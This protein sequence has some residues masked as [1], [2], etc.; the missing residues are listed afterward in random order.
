MFSLLTK[1]TGEIQTETGLDQIL[2]LNQELFNNFPDPIYIIN[3]AGHF[4][5]VNE[6]ACLLT[7]MSREEMQNF[8]FVP[9]MDPAYLDITR[10][11]FA[12]ACQ[13][14]PQQ[15]QTAIVTNT[16]LKHLDITN[17]PIK[18]EGGVV[19]VFG[20]AKDITSKRQKELDLQKY[21][22][23][24]KAQNEELE[25]L[26]KI[27]AHDMRKPLSNTIS[28]ARLLAG[29]NLPAENEKEVKSLLLRT[30][31]SLDSMVRDLN[32]VIALRFAGKDSQE[33]VFVA[34]SLHHILALF[35]LEIKSIQAQVSIQADPALSLVTMKA[36]FD[37]ILRNL[38]SNALKYHSSQ[39]R[40][41]LVVRAEV[42]KGELV[43]SV[44]DN[45]VGMDMSQVS[46]DLF[47][48]YRR[49]APALAEGKGLGLYIVR[50]QVNLLG[51]SIDVKSEPGIGSE[52]LLTLPV[53]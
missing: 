42:N 1:D 25:M 40:P 32:E 28:F 20:I 53:A 4:M 47:K 24:L 6:Q 5:M 22:D 16:G 23:L 14:Q 10:E 39:R 31:E 45:G 41:S 37:S 9:L 11:H 19:A 49:F 8:S 26:R 48:M 3:P 2:E 21:A 29:D 13:G 34:A 52:F 36:Y 15:Y 7:G 51:G 44:K 33:Q 12:L 18:E 50:Q 30:V 38:I 46:S 35:D 27:L 17:L 43:I